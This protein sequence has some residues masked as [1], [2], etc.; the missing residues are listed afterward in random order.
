MLLLAIILLVNFSFFKY[1]T[2]LDSAHHAKSRYYVQK[3]AHE[4]EYKIG[5]NAY[6]N[7]CGIS[8]ATEQGRYES[9]VSWS[10]AYNDSGSMH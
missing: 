1:V 7:A 5:S 9:Y 2:G 4:A 6:S 3:H 10:D 8:E